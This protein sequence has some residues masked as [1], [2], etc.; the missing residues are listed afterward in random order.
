MAALG[1]QSTGLLGTVSAGLGGSRGGDG[2]GA[3]RGL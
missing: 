2:E 1:A 3:L